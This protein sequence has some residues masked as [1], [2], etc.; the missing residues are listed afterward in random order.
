M[1]REKCFDSGGRP[2]RPQFCSRYFVFVGVCDWVPPQWRKGFQ[3]PLQRL[4]EGFQRLNKR[5]KYFKSKFWFIHKALIVLYF[6]LSLLIK[7]VYPEQWIEL[8][9]CFLSG[10]R[11]PFPSNL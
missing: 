4:P 1:S 5:S 6:V 3:L 9:N 10:K 11:F 8:T 7:S 2:R